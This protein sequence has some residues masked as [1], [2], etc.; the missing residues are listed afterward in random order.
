VVTAVVTALALATLL[1]GGIAVAGGNES[2][3]WGYGDY[4]YEPYYLVENI[5]TIDPHTNG[6]SSTAYCRE[7]DTVIGGG[8]ALE[9]HVGW[10]LYNSS[11]FPD[12]GSWHVRADRCCGT[13]C[14]PGCNQGGLIYARAI[15]ADV[16]PWDNWNSD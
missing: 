15:C 7:G 16:T 5:A 11:P 13:V 14:G 12:L 2:P 9:P 10:S 6:A 3:D 1:M 8:F 4:R